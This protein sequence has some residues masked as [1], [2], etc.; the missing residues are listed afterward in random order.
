V[1]D[2][3]NNRQSAHLWRGDSD[4]LSGNQTRAVSSMAFIKNK[5]KK[6]KPYGK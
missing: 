2:T 1:G 4:Y 6:D 5:E 3:G